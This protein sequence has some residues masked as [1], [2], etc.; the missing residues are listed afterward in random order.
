MSFDYLFKPF[1]IGNV[2]I[3]NR[4]A[5]AP[6]GVCL[7][8]GSNEIDDTTVA[9]F[10]ARAKGGYGLITSSPAC[11]DEEFSGIADVGQYYL[12]RP[13]HVEGIRKL[14]EAV[15]RHDSKI[16]IQLLHPGRQGSS[17]MSHGQQPVAPSAIKE[18]DF[19]WLEM[20]RE[21]S[22]EE[23]YSL[24]DKYIISA[25]YAYEGGADGVELHGA[26]GYLIHQFMSPRANK[27]TDEFGGSFENR[28]NFITKIVKGILEIKPE[29]A[30]LSVRI[31]A[32]DFIDGGL[33]IEDGKQIAKY[34]ESI[35]VEAISISGGTYSCQ[36]VLIEAQIREEG[37]RQD[38]FLND[39]KG[40][41]SIPVLAANHIKR[42][43]TAEKMLKDGICDC[44]LL[45]RQS[46][47]DPN[48]AKKAQEGRADQ[49][50][51]CISCNHCTDQV[52]LGRPVKCSV[53]PYLSNESIYNE[54]TIKKD[55]NGRKIVV[56]GG[57]PAGMEAALTAS[58]RGFRVTLFEK[59]G[60][61]GGAI[62]LPR[63]AHGMSKVGYSVDAF[64][65]RIMASDVEVVMNTEITSYEQ[66]APLKPY[67][68]VIAVGGL[69][70]KFNIPGI[71]QENVVQAV[72]VLRN[73]ENY[74][75]KNVILVG[76]GMTGLETAEVLA[77]NGCKINMFEM[78]DEIAKNANMKNKYAV[79][80]YL[81]SK[82]VL[83]HLNSK[84]CSINGNK[85]EFEN[86]AEKKMEE[87]TADVIVLSMGVKP[88]SAIADAF[89][90]KVPNLIT[91]GDCSDGRL[92]VHATSKA[93][94][95]IWNLE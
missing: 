58:K 77:A 79:L 34:L 95:E 8:P 48:W 54:H 84:L 83:V 10:E 76:S 45:G 26:H 90:E 53:N 61:L 85:V 20:P 81:L 15:H 14:T 27:R 44:V 17:A 73:P 19:D 35:G 60:R 7:N 87:Y 24:I 52:M 86:L 32:K 88:D 13:E 30:F 69:P 9:Y 93:F 74:R 18:A 70:V 63:I 3:K 38:A 42:P 51:Y 65:S 33:Q 25:K 91:A 22:T 46:M 49:I 31:N 78:Q 47:A 6:M 57:G 50:R 16:A 4:I 29:N 2:E 82:D 39:F 36:D 92:V 68:V 40:L 56:I 1:K 59:N 43:A 37:W 55:G 89:K 41:L 62:D 28:M 71:E 12:T 23:V 80:N 72:D 64:I 94:L 21:L 66:I 67:A 11:I 75:N 5:S